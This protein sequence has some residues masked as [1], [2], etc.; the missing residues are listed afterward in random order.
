[1]ILQATDGRTV[2]LVEISPPAKTPP[3]DCF[4]CEGQVRVGDDVLKACFSVNT[5]GEFMWWAFPLTWWTHP[6]AA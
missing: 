3:R 4:F 6:H 5:S 2:T 1:M